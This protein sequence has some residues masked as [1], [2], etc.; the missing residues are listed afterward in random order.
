MNK[1]KMIKPESD[2]CSFF[3]FFCFF[4]SCIVKHGLM[5]ASAST[6]YFLLTIH[7]WDVEDFQ[8]KPRPSVSFADISLHMAAA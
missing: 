2:N 7:L 3:G 5:K 4:P 6:I 8:Q 1:Y